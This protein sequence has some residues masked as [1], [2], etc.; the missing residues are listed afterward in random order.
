[1]ETKSTRQPSLISK[2]ILGLGT[3]HGGISTVKNLYGRDGELNT[4]T[5]VTVANDARDRVLS[6]PKAFAAGWANRRSRRIPP[7]TQYS[8]TNI[9]KTDASQK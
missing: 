7:D 6:C 5:A 1:M 9:E 2:A 4:T 3:G 8:N